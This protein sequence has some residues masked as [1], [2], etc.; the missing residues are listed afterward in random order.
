MKNNKMVI[1]PRNTWESILS[2]F[3]YRS[4]NN[5]N[6]ENISIINIDKDHKKEEERQ[7]IGTMQLPSNEQIRMIAQRRNI[8]SRNRIERYD[9][10]KWSS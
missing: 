5:G 6:S 8:I 1:L 4:I 7:E 9:I 3:I 10:E 2:T